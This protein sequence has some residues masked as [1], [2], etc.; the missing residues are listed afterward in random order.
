[1]LI[2]F[3]I[4]L[5]G[6]ALMIQPDEYA[7]LA[8]CCGCCCSCALLLSCDLLCFDKQTLAKWL[9]FP[10]LLHVSPFA[11]HAIPMGPEK[12]TITTGILTFCFFV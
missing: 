1:M 5:F 10:H 6:A 2:T 3:A 4:G 8:Y 12:S 7:N 9:I 11:G